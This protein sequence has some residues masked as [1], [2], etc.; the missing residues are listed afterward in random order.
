MKRDYQ[1]EGK[2]ECFRSFKVGDT[3]MGVFPSLGELDSLCS[4]LH[5]FNA[6]EGRMKE[7]FIRHRKDRVRNIA[8]LV[9][10]PREERDDELKGVKYAKEWKSR[11]P[12]PE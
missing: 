9:C 4:A 8:Y 11:Y 5:T 6:G 12:I 2:R 1:N 10:V 7:L 3:G